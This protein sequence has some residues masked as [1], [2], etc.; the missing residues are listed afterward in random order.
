MGWG[1]PKKLRPGL[2]CQVSS[3]AR[4]FLH[5]TPQRGP[6]LEALLVL[7]SYFSGEE[8]DDSLKWIFSNNGLPFLVPGPELQCK[9]ESVTWALEG[10]SG[11]RDEHR[12][13]CWEGT[14]VR[15]PIPVAH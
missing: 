7:S 11:E 5:R 12:G 10:G 6:A 3:L 1:I 14:G 13:H 2:R 9:R 4:E 8:G 15:G